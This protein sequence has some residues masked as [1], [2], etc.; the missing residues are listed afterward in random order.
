M[1]LSEKEQ[2]FRLQAEIC[3]TMSDAKR[4]RIIHELREGELPVNELCSRLGLSQS[5]TSQHL[6][7]LRRR[8]LVNARRE[9]TSIYYS[10]ANDRIAQAC[11]IVRSVLND[12]L[13]SNQ[14]L[15]ARLSQTK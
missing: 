12:Q 10:L 7:I 3:K 13:K 2:L 4:L 8:G 9:G 14:D 1:N 6:S 15:A 11:D 5:N